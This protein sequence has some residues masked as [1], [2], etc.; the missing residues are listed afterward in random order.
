MTSLGPM[1][2]RSEIEATPFANSLEYVSY[3]VHNISSGNIPFSSRYISMRLFG[4][5]ILH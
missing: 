5:P 4:F 3:A 2:N 1:I